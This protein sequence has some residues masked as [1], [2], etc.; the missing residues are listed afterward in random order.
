M[1]LADHGRD[2]AEVCGGIAPQVST[3]K[4]LVRI[5]GLAVCLPEEAGVDVRTSDPTILML[6]SLM[7]S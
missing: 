7:Y 2:G 3:W 4:A 5:L 6:G 1:H